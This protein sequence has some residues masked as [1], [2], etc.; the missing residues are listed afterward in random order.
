MLSNPRIWKPELNIRRT[1]MDTGLVCVVRDKQREYHRVSS[2]SHDRIGRLLPKSEN[3]GSGLYAFPDRVFL[4]PE[5]EQAVIKHDP[6][7]TA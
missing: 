6:I 7:P 5:S 3:Q 4:S 2:F 1:L